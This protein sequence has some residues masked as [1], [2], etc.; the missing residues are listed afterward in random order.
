MK[1]KKFYLKCRLWKEM[2]Y[3]FFMNKYDLAAIKSYYF[4]KYD[5]NVY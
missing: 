1:I 5:E 2:S 4:D 3:Y